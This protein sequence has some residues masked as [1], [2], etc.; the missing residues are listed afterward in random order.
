MKGRHNA[1]RP[2]P[3]RYRKNRVYPLFKHRQGRAFFMKI[4]YFRFGM[5]TTTL[6][7]GF[8]LLFTIGCGPVYRTDYQFTPPSSSTGKVCASNCENSKYQC[9]QIEQM[10]ADQCQ[11]RARLE[12][13][14]CEDNVR[15]R[16]G[17]EP[18]WYECGMD[19]CSADTE[20][21]ESQYRSCFTACG[22]KVDAQT[23]CVANCEQVPQPPPAPAKRSEYKPAPS[24]KKAKV[25]EPDN[26]P[27]RRY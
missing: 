16:E 20:R 19:S 5:K 11:D 12:M 13:Q 22:G 17:R 18:K 2:R 8:T 6:L 10:R 9:Q 25:A 7:G 3:L 21:C 24:S 14:R 27:Y 4:H 15:W 1:N 23:I 26:D